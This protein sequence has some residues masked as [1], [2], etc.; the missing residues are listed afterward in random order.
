GD[1]LW[2][3]L[4]DGHKSEPITATG[5]FTLPEKE[6]GEAILELTLQEASVH[7]AVKAAEGMSGDGMKLWWR[8]GV[9]RL[10]VGALGVDRIWK[11]RERLGDSE[12]EGLSP[13]DLATTLVQGR[14][15]RIPCRR[16][17]TE[18]AMT[19]ARG[20][21]GNGEE[22]KIRCSFILAEGKR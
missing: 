4:R 14:T 18:G 9:Q 3:Q 16:N 22:D 6:G 10:G 11:P 5:S 7:R 1:A 13:A 17:K 2:Q 8:R 19:G 15:L 12:A 21:L 20:D